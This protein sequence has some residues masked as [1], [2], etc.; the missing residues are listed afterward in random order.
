MKITYQTRPSYAE[1]GQSNPIRWVILSGTPD[2]GFV[3]ESS[4]LKC[5]DFFNDYAVAYN[6]GKR[7]AIYGFSTEGMAIPKQGEYVYMAVKHLTKNFITNMNTFNKW[8]NENKCP[9]IVFW[10]VDDTVVLQLDP[11]FLKNTYNISLVSLMIRLLNDE[12]FNGTIEE[13]KTHKI[14]GDG[15]DQQK[16]G[17]VVN[18]KVFFD[19]P[20]KLDKFLWYCGEGHNSEK[21]IQ[22]YQLPSLVHNNGVVSWSSYF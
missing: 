12:T 22:V 6:G 15:R 4:W 7:F 10:P 20:K 2:T 11:F 1:E 21:D 18:K 3:N 14:P 19:I 17:V 13:L 5:K 16:W 8:L 9:K